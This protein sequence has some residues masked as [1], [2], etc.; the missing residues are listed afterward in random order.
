MREIQVTGD[1][2]KIFGGTPRQ[3]DKM[4]DGGALPVALHH[5]FCFLRMERVSF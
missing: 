4:R 5:G 2:A 1:L 3:E